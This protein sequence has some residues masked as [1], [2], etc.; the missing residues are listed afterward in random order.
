MILVNDEVLVLIILI[1]SNFILCHVY[2]DIRLKKKKN[3]GIWL[4][5]PPRKIQIIIQLLRYCERLI[6]R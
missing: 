5:K 1:Q 3:E 4:K 2:Y 6:L